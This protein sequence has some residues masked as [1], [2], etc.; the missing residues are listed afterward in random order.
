MEG[1]VWLPVRFGSTRG[2]ATPSTTATQL[3]VVPRSIP[4][5]FA[6]ASPRVAPC[7][8]PHDRRGWLV[9]FAAAA[10]APRAASTLRRRSRPAPRRSRVSFR[11]HRHLHHRGTQQTSVMPVALLELL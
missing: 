11:G 10:A 4:R 7:H 9:H 5:I 1:V 3:L 2:V 6:N 8:R